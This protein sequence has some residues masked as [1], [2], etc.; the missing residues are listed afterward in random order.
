MTPTAVPADVEVAERGDS[1]KNEEWRIVFARLRDE[2]GIDLTQV[3]E[4]T[5]LPIPFLSDI[6]NGLRAPTFAE[7]RLV[8][9]GLLTINPTYTWIC[10]PDGA[11]F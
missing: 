6:A 2:A 5:G 10:W 7:C 8:F 3:A 9:D 1:I 4:R 11:P